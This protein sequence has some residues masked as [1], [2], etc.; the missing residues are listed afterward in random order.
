MSL[1]ILHRWSEVAK[2]CGALITEH[3]ETRPLFHPDRALG[4]EQGKLDMW[5]DM[6]P[7]DS[8]QPPPG[9]PVDISPRK[10]KRYI[11]VCCIGRLH[12]IYARVVLANINII[13]HVAL[14]LI[15]ILIRDRTLN[16][17]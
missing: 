12:F 6:F 15:M 17:R 3:V 8:G 7:M 2:G 4:I 16:L 1:A 13:I 5:V 10:P 14:E 11:A 9:P